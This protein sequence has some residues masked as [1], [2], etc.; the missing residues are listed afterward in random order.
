MVG[1]RLDPACFI[2]E[3]SQFI[4]HEADEPEMVVELLDAEPLPGHQHLPLAL[5][6]GV[7][8]KH[9]AVNRR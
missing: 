7:S 8:G 5:A 3:I 1:D 9:V 4:V 2:V 6:G